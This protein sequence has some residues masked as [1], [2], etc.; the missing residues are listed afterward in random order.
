M[1]SYAKDKTN[2]G[3]PC[4]NTASGNFDI[5]PDPEEILVHHMVAWMRKRGRTDLPAPAPSQPRDAAQWWMQKMQEPQQLGETRQLALA[6]MQDGQRWETGYANR[7]A[8]TF[9]RWADMPEVE[10]EAVCA[11]VIEDRVPYRGEYFPFYR[12]LVDT[13]LKMRESGNRAEYAGRALKRARR[14]IDRVQR[15]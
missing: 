6:G 8:F 11:G 3:S 13:T 9:L 14:L 5:P 12:D 10:R 2:Q 4:G 7:C 15:S 1:A